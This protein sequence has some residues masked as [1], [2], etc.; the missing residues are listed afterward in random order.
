MAGKLLHQIV[1]FC[2]KNVLRAS[3][4][5][6]NFF[7]GY[8]PNLTKREEEKYWDGKRERGEGGRKKGREGR[9]V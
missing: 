4:T 9:D 7:L 6:K 2:V 8:T 1:K 3:V 5:S